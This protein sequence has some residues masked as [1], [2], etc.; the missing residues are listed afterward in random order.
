MRIAVVNNF[1][2]PRVGGSSHLS[3]SL[4]RGYAAAGHQVLVLTAAYEEAPEVEERDG[5]RI[6]R[7]PAATIPKSRLSVSFDIAFT[8]RRGA[9]RNVA[10]ALEEFAP[11]AIHQHGQFFDLTWL[12]G[13]WAR[14][15]KVPTLLSVHTRLEN[16]VAAYHGVF[17]G[18]DAGLVRPVLRAY[19][20]R[21]VV[22]DVQMEEYI[23]SRYAGA[24][25]GL[26]YIPVGVDAEWVRGGE[27]KHIRERHDLLDNPI[28]L[29]LGHVIPLRDR[30]T[31]VEAMPEVLRRHPH[32]RLVIVGRVYY[33]V[34]LERAR[35][36]GVGHAVLAIGAVSKAEVPDYL[37]A[38]DVE[39]HDLQGYGLGTASLESMAASVPTVVA[40]REDNFPGIELH[41]G[42]NVVLT[43]VGDPKALGQTLGD[44][45]DD[46]AWRERLGKAERELVEARFSMQTVL[47]Q[48]LDVLAA[49]AGRSRA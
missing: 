49:M 32:A 27:G 13:L 2:P 10:A 20:P 31:L 23:T 8:L 14:R 7:L 41:S 48:H 26:E 47:R 16:P 42:E 36:L 5:L 33:D 29:S 11:D 6:V 45:L 25:S 43:P 17:R 24:Y 28:I 30:V 9:Y 44:L 12:T 35:E 21:L 37:A 34:C 1:F 22:M 15:H 19:R 39:T 3:D 18:L 46:P 40:V 38:A 4:A